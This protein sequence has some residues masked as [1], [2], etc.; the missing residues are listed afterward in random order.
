MKKKGNCVHQSTK[1]KVITFYLK[2]LKVLIVSIIPL[3]GAPYFIYVDNENCVSYAG[4]VN[5]GCEKCKL[6][7]LPL[8]MSKCLIVFLRVKTEKS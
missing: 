6:H 4:I 2:I 5:R 8:Y 3:R 7:E 1:N